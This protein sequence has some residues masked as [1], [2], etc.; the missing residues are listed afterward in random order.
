M[1][2]SH[3]LHLKFKLRAGKFAWGIKAKLSTNFWNKKI[4]DIIQQCFAL[5]PQ[6]NIPANNLNFQ[7]RWRCWDRI[8]A[9]FLNLFYF[10]KQMSTKAEGCRI[11][12]GIP[13]WKAHGMYLLAKTIFTYEKNIFTTLCLVWSEVEFTATY[14]S[15]DIA[16]SQSFSSGE[17]RNKKLFLFTTVFLRRNVILLISYW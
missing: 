2:Q 5:L 6:V 11:L 9:I 17:W 7:G 3:H 1:V 4:V 12:R 14:S 15:P 10:K 16:Q 13:I 8:L